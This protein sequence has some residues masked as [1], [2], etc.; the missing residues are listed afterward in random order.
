MLEVS[1]AAVIQGWDKLVLDL[2]ADPAFVTEQTEWDISNLSDP[3]ATLPTRTVANVLS[4]AAEVSKCPHFGL[5]LAKRRDLKTYLGLVGQ[6][7]QAAETLGDGLREGFKLFTLHSQGPHWVLHSSGTVSY[8][9]RHIDNFLEHGSV[10]STQL[11]VGLMWRLIRLLSNGKWH[12]TMVSLSFKK[13]VNTLVYKRFFSAPILFDADVSS[14][15]FHTDDLNI[16]LPRHDEYLLNVLKTYAET[17]QTAP[18]RDLKDE[19]TDLVRK[20]LL[21]GQTEIEQ[22]AKFF[23]FRQRALQRKLNSLGTSYRQILHDVRL[24][25]A[26][27]R[28]LNSSSSLS[29]I[30]D[31]LGYLDQGSFTKAFKSQT[32]L[33][34]RA[35]RQQTQKNN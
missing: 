35:W 6:V 15:T 28:M 17:I 34:P 22:I 8:V 18:R 1:R 27:D 19:V 9:T 23:P 32:G 4:R 29:R 13:P 3:D 33:T 16:A 11:A 2:G 25:V 26:K 21:E 5:L 14:V 12:P 30:A 7:T 20:N 31:A 24:S 10:Q